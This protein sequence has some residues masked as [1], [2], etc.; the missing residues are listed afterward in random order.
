MLDEEE[1]Q[2]VELIE[3]TDNLFTN[4]E[5]QRIKILEFKNDEDLLFWGE[6]N[7]NYTDVNFKLIVQGNNVESSDLNVLEIIE[8]FC[9][10]FPVNYE[11]LIVFRIKF[12]GE[13][14]DAMVYLLEFFDDEYLPSVM[15][16]DL[17]FSMFDKGC[18]EGLASD[19][20]SDEDEERA[21]KVEVDDYFNKEPW[22]E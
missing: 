21:M 16:Y 1:R 18:L 10:L 15:I 9:V 5:K 2:C 13:V 22:G 17:T 8:K 3:F 12:F 4:L 19:F 6:V 7:E 20:E 11:D 14:A